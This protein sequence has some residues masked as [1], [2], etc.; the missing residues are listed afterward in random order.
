LDDTTNRIIDQ[1]PIIKKQRNSDKERIR[2]EVYTSGLIVTAESGKR[3][4]LFETN[5]GHAGEFI[6]D[7]LKNRTR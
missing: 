4:V 6:D 2:K 1:Q 5:V 7:I 3:I